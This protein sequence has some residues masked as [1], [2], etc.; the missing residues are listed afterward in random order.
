MEVVIRC[1]IHKKNGSHTIIEHPEYV[2]TTFLNFKAK[3]Q[4]KREKIRQMFAD[5]SGKVPEDITADFVFR[6]VIV[7]EGIDELSENWQPEEVI[8]PKKKV[9]EQPI[10]FDLL[11]VAEYPFRK[12]RFMNQL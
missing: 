10:S 11:D 1:F 9:K 6:T 5:K 8:Y 12:P 3:E 4:W 2:G 7:P